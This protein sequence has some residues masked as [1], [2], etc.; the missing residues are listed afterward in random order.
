MP[1]TVNLRE[2]VQPPKRRC[3][4]AIHLRHKVQKNKH[5]VVGVMCKSWK[6]DTCRPHIQRKW[7]EHLSCM[8]QVSSSLYVSLISKSRWET[9]ATR[10]RRANAQFASVEQIGEILMVFTNIPEGEQVSLEAALSMLDR[11]IKNAIIDHR[12]VHTSRGWGFPKDTTPKVSEW[13][14]VKKLSITV[15]D[16][17]EAVAGAGLSIKQFWCDTRY[18]FVVELPDESDDLAVDLAGLLCRIKGINGS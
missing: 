15:D 1:G 8:F 13:E 9:V 11:A 18:G 16:A 10:I 4:M 3:G 7:F 6:C 17:K 5:M 12:P 14:R 2:L